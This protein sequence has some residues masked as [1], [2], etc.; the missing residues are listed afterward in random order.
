S[1]RKIAR[2]IAGS[3]LTKAAIFGRDPNWGRI[4]AAAGRAD[5]PFNQDDLQIKLGDF[6]MMD[7]GQP[8][9]FDRIAANAYLKQAAAGAYLQDD[10]VLIALSVG[11]GSGIGT[12]WGCDLSYDYVKINAE[13]TT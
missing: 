1:A 2:A 13:Y 8:Q 5:V 4:A 9:P 3:S 12:A 6:L 10:T 7:Q 11:D